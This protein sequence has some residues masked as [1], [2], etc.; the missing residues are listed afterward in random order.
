MPCTVRVNLQNRVVQINGVR[1]PVETD[2]RDAVFRKSPQPLLELRR[3]KSGA[4]AVEHSRT[5]A[6]RAGGGRERAVAALP[7]KGPAGHSCSTVAARPPAAARELR[8]P[9]SSAA[10]I[11]LG[12]RVFPRP[13]PP[14][15]SA[16]RSGARGAGTAAAAQRTSPPKRRAHDPALHRE[17][18]HIPGGR[19]EPARTRR[20]SFGP[21]QSNARI[22]PGNREPTSRLTSAPLVLPKPRSV[23]AC[24]GNPVDDPRAFRCCGRS[25]RHRPSRASPNPAEPGDDGTPTRRSRRTD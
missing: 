17:S 3:P 14:P 4:E 12:N 1:S 2:I 9:P 23:S 7:T 13:C 5:T 21:G 18:T 19:A 16:C 11:G 20:A 6:A 25:R 22:P 10:K 8:P 24:V 15:T